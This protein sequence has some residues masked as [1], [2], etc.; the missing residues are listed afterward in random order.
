MAGQFWQQD[1]ATKLLKMFV[2]VPPGMNYLNF[3]YSPFLPKSGSQKKAPQLG[4]KS[5]PRDGNV[6]RVGKVV[7]WRESNWE[8]NA[9]VSVVSEKQFQRER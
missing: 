4:K 7:P 8:Y 9:G 1:R 6:N 5:R 2:K 3:L